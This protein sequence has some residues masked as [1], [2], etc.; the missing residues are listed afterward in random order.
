MNL[1][2][3]RPRLRNDLATFFVGVMLGFGFGIGW[4][5]V[6]LLVGLVWGQS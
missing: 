3:Y 2:L 5:V 4:Q 6:R 1:K